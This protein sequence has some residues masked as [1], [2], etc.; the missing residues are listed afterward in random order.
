MLGDQLFSIATTLIAGKT[1]TLISDAALAAK[2]QQAIIARKKANKTKSAKISWLNKFG[3]AGQDVAKT[4]GL[5]AAE[6]YE[7]AELNG[8]V[9]SFR[10]SP[11]SN[12]TLFNQAEEHFK[13]NESG[14]KA[15]RAPRAVQTAPDTIKPARIINTMPKQEFFK[16]TNIKR[17]YQSIG[18]DGI[19]KKKSNVEGILDIEYLQWDHLHNEVE[20]YNKHGKHL[21]ALDPEKMTLYKDYVSGRKIDI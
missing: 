16:K 11:A 2:L 3:V 12:Q 10:N 19:W 18:R 6:E 13:R 21:G 14:K 20:A 17:D 1:V 4:L 7:L 5:I 9:V 8:L 15:K